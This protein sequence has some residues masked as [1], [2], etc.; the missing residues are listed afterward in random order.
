MKERII[1]LS[2]I[3]MMLSGCQSNLRQDIDK[4]AALAAEQCVLLSS[5]LGERQMPRTFQGDTLVQS[6]LKA[7]TSGFFPGTCWYAYMLTKDESLKDIAVKQT[8]KLICP[9]EYLT[10]HDAGF[11][12]MCSL[13]HAY[14]N[15]GEERYHQGIKEAAEFLSGRYSA[16]TGVIKS[17][18][19]KHF[20]YPVIID[21]MMNLELLTYASREFGVSQWMDIAISHADV[22]MRNHFREDGSSYHLV[23][24]DPQTGEVVQKV[25][26]QGYS[27][28]SAWSRGQSW[29]LYGYTMMY[30][31]TGYERYLNHAEK[32]ASYL[33]IR[34]KDR[35][36]PA[37]DFDADQE[38]IE[39]T[40]ASAAAVMASAFIR[41][42]T[43][44]KDENKSE[45]YLSQAEA[46]M[47]ALMKPGFLACSGENG[48]FL[49][50][51]STGFYRNNREVNVPLTYADYYFLEA[52]YSYKSISR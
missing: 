48:G 12:V 2:V 7:W 24:Y 36:I 14:K 21:N 40:D 16:T 38:S 49:L 46:I 13:G 31:E 28:D 35:P 44:T 51:R 52:L 20:K 50:K 15:T 29:G 45:C 3:A 30:D 8:E 34:L 32:I 25:T 9:M 1:L 22:T 33:L 17:W 18:D 26:V 41:L 5:E 47:R 19:H 23:N 11:Q 39:Q 4:V 37:W 10:D 43:L 42:S 27:D 6:N